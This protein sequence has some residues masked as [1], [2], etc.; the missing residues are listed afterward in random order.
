MLFN[1]PCKR[2]PAQCLSFYKQSHQANNSISAD[3]PWLLYAEYKDTYL[4]DWRQRTVLRKWNLHRNIILH[5]DFLPPRPPSEVELKLGR[6]A[7]GGGGGGSGQRQQVL[8]ISV[9][10]DH[11]IKLWDCSANEMRIVDKL[12]S[13]DNQ[14]FTAFCV[15]RKHNSDVRFVENYNLSFF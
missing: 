13:P 11:S 10:F 9:A 1:H 12:H 4:L 2:T 8:A 15:R 6:S 7:V 5:L 3:R 14:P